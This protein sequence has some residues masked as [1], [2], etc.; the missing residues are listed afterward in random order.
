MCCFIKIFIEVSIEVNFT[1][2]NKNSYKFLL[3]ISLL[4]ELPVLLQKLCNYIII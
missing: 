1:I 4:T 2:M 3:E